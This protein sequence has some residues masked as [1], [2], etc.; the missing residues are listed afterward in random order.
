MYQQQHN[1]ASPPLHHPVPQHPIPPMRSPPPLQ[2]QGRPVNSNP[3]LPQGGAASGYAPDNAGNGYNLF[4]DT[5]AQVGLQV[6]RNAVLAGQE[7]VE[8]NF[9]RFMSLSMPTL[10]SYFNVSNGYVGSKLLLVLFPWR[11]KL[12]SRQ[13]KRSEVSGSV[14]GFMPPRE[15]INAPDMYIPVM[16]FTT[17][18]LLSSILAGIKGVFHPEIL[19]YISSVAFAIVI[20]EILGLRLGCYLLGISNDSQLLDLV[21][22]SGYKFIGV[23]L[24]MIAGAL[25]SGYF[26]KYS[27]F[28]YTFAANAFFLL[29]SLRYVVLPESPVNPSSMNTTSRQRQRR[30]QFLFAYSFVCQFVLMWMLAKS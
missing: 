13:P 29:R 6:G 18:I 8:Q 10:R 3:Y 15:D 4:N 22:Y 1:P 28:L 21:A 16:A 11:H 24:T 5:T 23:I 9:G 12:W 17:Y 2:Q 14:E 20:F 30:I 7:Y 19:G 25:V 26:V 27:V